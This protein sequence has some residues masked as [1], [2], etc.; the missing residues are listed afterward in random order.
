MDRSD[1]PWRV[2]DNVAAAGP[3]AVAGPAAANTG[4]EGEERPVS[5]RVPMRLIAG[6]M[7][8]AALAVA[9]FSV[10]ATGS[11]GG[12]VTVDSAAAIVAG[13]ARPSGGSAAPLAG[14]LVVD[15]QGAVL[16]P[17][18]HHLGPGSRVADAIAAAGGYGPRVDADRAGREL[19]LAAQ[20]HDG[21]RVLVP[22]RDDPS[23]SG[24]GGSASGS[25][26]N[27]TGG[28][29]T[30]GGST[31]GGGGS[32]GSR[33]S[34]GRPG[35]LVDLNHATASELDALPGVGPVTA[36]KI[37]AAREEQPFPTIEALRDRKVIGAAAFDKLKDLVTVTP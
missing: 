24:V 23:G 13:S 8:A 27:S 33:G 28:G 7:A 36:Q 5:A 22:S 18:V 9:A 37:I 35:A 11:T 6:L 15:V 17:G 4:G 1:S 19:N 30:G 34:G 2:L 26:G 14:D 20:L 10:A 21:D 25:G 16:R 31:G 3:A 12:G 29:S 32:G